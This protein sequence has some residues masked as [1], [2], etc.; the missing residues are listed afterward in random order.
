MIERAHMEY[1]PKWHPIWDTLRMALIILIVVSQI[2][3]LVR[4]GGWEWAAAI[5]AVVIIGMAS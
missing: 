3:I 1:K 4:D 5:A 2:V